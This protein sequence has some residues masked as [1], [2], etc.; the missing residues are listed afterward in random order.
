MSRPFV[1]WKPVSGVRDTHKA[2]AK[3]RR[4]SGARRSRRPQG[5]AVLLHLFLHC[6]SPCLFRSASLSTAIRGPPAGACA[7][8]YQSISVS[9][10][11]LAV[12]LV[13]F[14]FFCATH[15]LRLSGASIYEQTCAGTCSD[16]KL[17]AD[18][19][20]VIFQDSAPYSRTLKTLLLKSPIFS[21]GWCSWISK[22]LAFEIR[23][24]ISSSFLKTI[25]NLD[26]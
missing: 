4:S 14:L 21:S 6:P 15:S 2:S 11:G 16:F 7:A 1:A 10:A 20:L 17:L 12:W 13:M 8:Q 18:G 5:L 9:F 3:V 19:V 25:W 22:W 23:T 24:R 26:I